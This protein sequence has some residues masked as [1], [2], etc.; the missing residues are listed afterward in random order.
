MKSETRTK[1]GML[2][3]TFILITYGFVLGRITAPSKQEKEDED[4]E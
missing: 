2:I 1:I 4:E 3:L